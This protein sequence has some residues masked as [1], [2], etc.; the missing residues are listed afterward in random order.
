MLRSVGIL[1]ME[2]AAPVGHDDVLEDGGA[3]HSERTRRQSDLGHRRKVVARR[4]CLCQMESPRAN[5]CCNARCDTNR[6]AAI[7]SPRAISYPDATVQEN[8]YHIEFTAPGGEIYFMHQ[9]A[10]DEHSTHS[11]SKQAILRFPALVQASCRQ[12]RIRELGF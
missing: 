9:A 10:L 4:F 5:I 8:R 11:G 12:C 1:R 2:D 7:S 6:S 3:G